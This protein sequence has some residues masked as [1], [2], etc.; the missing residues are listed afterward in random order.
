[1]DKKHV[2]N[3]YQAVIYMCKYLSKNEDQYSQAM[4]QEAKEDFGNNMYHHKNIKKKLLK[5]V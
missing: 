3:K 2:L 4:K 1:M 5:F